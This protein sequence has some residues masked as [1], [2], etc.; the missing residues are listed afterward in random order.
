MELINLKE[1][2]SAI[3]DKKGITIKYEKGYW[4][5]IIKGDCSLQITITPKEMEKIVNKMERKI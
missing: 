2:K 4:K 1:G 5:N 3:L